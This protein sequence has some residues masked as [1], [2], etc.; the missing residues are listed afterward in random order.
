MA[1]SGLVIILGTVFL[2]THLA[3]I[4]VKMMK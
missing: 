4:L 2:G 1:L 3:S